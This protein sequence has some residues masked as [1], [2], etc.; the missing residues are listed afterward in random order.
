MTLFPDGA[1]TESQRETMCK[2]LYLAQLE[3]HQHGVGDV[4]GMHPISLTELNTS[5]VPNFS[6]RYYER[7]NRGDRP[8]MGFGFAFAPKANSRLHRA[9]VMVLDYSRWTLRHL[10]H[11]ICKY[12]FRF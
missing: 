6:P 2:G 8:D 10:V 12:F 7:R 3:C 1:C 11:F 9:R 5:D 4:S